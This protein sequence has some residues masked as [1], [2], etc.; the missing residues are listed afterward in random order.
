M[1]SLIKTIIILLTLAAFIYCANLAMQG[2]L[3]MA[4][5][6]AD[7]EQAKAFVQT[8]AGPLLTTLDEFFNSVHSKIR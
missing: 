2:K 1:S 7:Y 3:E 5:I 6:L 4:V 8:Q